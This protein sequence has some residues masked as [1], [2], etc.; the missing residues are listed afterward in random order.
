[1][2]V[3]KVRKL[4]ILIPFLALVVIVLGVTR[5]SHVEYE[6]WLQSEYNFICNKSEFE[7]DCVT[8][9]KELILFKESTIKDGY[10]L[11]S[12]NHT[13]Y[14]NHK[15]EEAINSKSIGI[16]NNFIRLDN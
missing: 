15:G 5:P 16:L 13:I 3:Q 6:K 1:M 12:F 9:D 8:K 7:E 10:L 11:L 2:K 14:I 4:S